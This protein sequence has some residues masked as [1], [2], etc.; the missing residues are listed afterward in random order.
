MINVKNNTERLNRLVEA[1]LKHVPFDGWNEEAV[2]LG[3]QN[4]AEPDSSFEELFNSDVS[5]IVEHYSAMLDQQMLEA[6]AAQNLK[7]M[8]IR[9]R[10]HTAVMARLRLMA[11]NRLAAKKA[12]AYLA[13]PQ[14]AALGTKLLY[15]TVNQI[16]YAAGDTA[17][18]FNFYTKRGLLAGVYASTLVYWFNDDSSKFEDTQTFLSRRIENVMMIHKLKARL[19]QFWPWSSNNPTG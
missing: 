12:C 17:T 13:M 10:V 1:T 11:A 14:H 7:E 3:I 6:L 8:K 5:K 9:D 16:W 19:K 18:D 15:R 4:L 2:M